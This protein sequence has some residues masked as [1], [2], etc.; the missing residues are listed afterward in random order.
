MREIKKLIKKSNL[1]LQQV[2]K[3]LEEINQ[4]NEYQR[5]IGFVGDQRP[6]QND[7]FPGLNS[8]F[9]AFQFDSF[10]LKSNMRDN[11]CYLRQGISIEI[12]EFA[13]WNEENV[14]LA[15]T[16]T[17]IR[18]FFDEPDDSL[19][20]LGILLV[21]GVSEETDMF[22]V[23]DIKYKYVRLPYQNHFV[24]LPILHHL[25]VNNVDAEYAINQ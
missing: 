15:K 17:N 20:E 14:V 18:R 19:E 11:C 5:N 1:V 23:A 16:F 12:Q 10:I 9:R 13:A 8:S 6:F 21:D 3:R 2:F 4:V 25:T 24:L 7:V 22:L